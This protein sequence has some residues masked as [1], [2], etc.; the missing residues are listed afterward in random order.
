MLPVL[1]QTLPFFALIGLGYVAGRTGFFPEEA[2][3]WLTKFVFYFALSAMIFRFAAD[4]SLGEVLTRDFVLAYLSATVAVYVLMMIVSLIRGRGLEEAAVEA[5]CGVIGNVGFLGLPMLA[6]LLGEA[7]IGPVMVVLAIDVTVF[8]SLI[9]ILITAR[10]DGRVSVRILWSVVKGLLQNPMIMSLVAGFAWSALALPIPGPFAAFLA[11]LGRGGDARGA[12]RD[13]RLARLEIG[14]AGGGG[15]LA[16]D[17]EAPD[18]SGGGGGGGALGVSGGALRGR[19]D[20]RRG[21]LAGGGQRVHPRAALRGGAEAG[22]GLDPRL[23]RPVGGDILGRDRVARAASGRVGW[24][25]FRRTAP[26]AGV[27]GVYRHRSAATGTT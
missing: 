7:A 22:V 26:S 6:M 20:D 21:G 1:L 8:G 11:I 4:L 2:T 18:P 27:Q 3:A 25:R 5:Q 17:R 9:V 24:R 19:R 10:R 15:A 16:L 12:F 23:D 13:R 14:R